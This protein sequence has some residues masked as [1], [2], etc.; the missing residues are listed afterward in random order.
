LGA[1]TG[2]IAAWITPFTACER[3][4]DGRQK[5]ELP[6]ALHFLPRRGSIKG[7][8]RLSPRFAFE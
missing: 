3:C 7:Y 6:H 1:V 5:K 2:P 8:F 4:D